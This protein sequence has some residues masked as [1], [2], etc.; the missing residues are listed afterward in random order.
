[1]K[2]LIIT[3]IVL[4]LAMPSL[5]FAIEKFQRTGKIEKDESGGYS[6]SQ[7]DYKHRRKKQIEEKTGAG[8]Y[9]GEYHTTGDKCTDKEWQVIDC[10]GHSGSSKKTAKKKK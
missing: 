2:K 10:P 9:D 6:Q 5:T 7:S 4:T 3:V 8:Y 1:M